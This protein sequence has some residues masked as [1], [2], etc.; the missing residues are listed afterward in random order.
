MSNSNGTGHPV[1]GIVLGIIGIL[2]AIIFSM[3]TGAISGAI[4]LILGI[5][6]IL[7]G[8]NARKLCGKGIGAIVTGA[9]AVILSIVMTVSSINTMKLL[10]QQAEEQG[11]KLAQY[12]TNPYLGIVGI[13]SNLPQDEASLTEIV[14]QLNELSQNTNAD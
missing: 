7:I 11:L 2:I 3:I 5:A 9:I 12:M 14:E 6:A 8:I 13:F 4:A 10:K 1:L